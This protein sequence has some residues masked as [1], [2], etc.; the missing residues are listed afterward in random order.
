MNRYWWST[1]YVIVSFSQNWGL[2]CFLLLC[3]FQPKYLLHTDL[4]YVLELLVSSLNN[5]KGIC[6]IFPDRVLPVISSY[7]CSFLD[8]IRCSSI[9]AHCV[10]FL[11]IRAT[12]SHFLFHFSA[13]RATVQAFRREDEL[14]L[15]KATKR[16]RERFEQVGIFVWY[17]GASYMI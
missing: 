11:L 8:L 10:C 5:Y 14:H 7:W 6:N 15:F 1:A 13:L 2:G 17:S 3:A 12:F 9:C 4:Y 16:K